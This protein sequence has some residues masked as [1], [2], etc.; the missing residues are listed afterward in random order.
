MNQNQLNDLYQNNK[1]IIISSDRPPKEISTLEERLVSRFSMG[2]I[3][4]IQ[5]PDFETRY[6][7]LQ[8]KAQMESRISSLHLLILPLQYQYI[9]I[10]R[11]NQ[12]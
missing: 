1:Q 10:E 6:V 12:R 11:R 2:L 7:I 4:D 3:Q 5:Q 9:Q 8:K